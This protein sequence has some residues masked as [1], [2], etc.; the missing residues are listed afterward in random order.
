MPKKVSND[1]LYKKIELCSYI[2]KCVFDY[3]EVR[4][5]CYLNTIYQI[6]IIIKLTDFQINK[7]NAFNIFYSV[8]LFSK[9]IEKL[10]GIRPGIDVK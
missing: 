8:L 5:L 9:S 2:T 10:L 4:I 6:I 1:I 7:N 3:F